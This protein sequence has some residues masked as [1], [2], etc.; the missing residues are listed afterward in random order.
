LGR[1]LREI[2]I[3]MMIFRIHKE[4][5]VVRKFHLYVIMFVISILSIVSN[6]EEKKR[7]ER[8]ALTL[9]KSIEL[10]LENN[11]DILIAKE[12]KN[13]ASQQIREARSGA[14]P[15]L[16]YAA[17]YT[18]TLVKPAFYV[19]VNGEAMKF[20]VGFSNSLM[21]IITLNQTLYSGGRTGTAI[22]IASIYSESFDESLKQTEK[23]VRLQVRQVFLGVL[24]NAEVLKI[25]RRSQESA[26]K[27]FNMVKTLHENGMASEFDLLR[28]EVELENT[29]PKVIQSENSLVLQKNVLKNLIGMPLEREIDII[30]TL[31]AGFLDEEVIKDAGKNAFYNRNDYKNFTLMRNAYYQNIRIERAAWFPFI[32]AQYTYQHQ[33]QSNDWAF[34]NAFA[35]HNIALNLSIPLF[36]GFRTSARVQQAKI[37]VKEMDFQLIKLQEGINIQ[38]TQAHNS[39]A[40]ARKRI[41][42]TKKTVE[43]AQRAYNIALVRFESGQGTQ[44]EIF[45]AQIALELAQLN[46]LQG[47]FDYE[48]AKAQ[49]ENAVGR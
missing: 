21:H 7:P 47:I 30:G 13:R 46:R 2:M 36:D 45:D 38:I 27:H 22:K 28:A 33:G 18:R 32:G 25:N 49:W 16:N 9:E 29:R 1:R 5:I 42:S 37:N 48:I 23:N 20:E 35:S 34:K 6:G 26:E 12:G 4:D 19:S 44:L 10:A 40:D 15:Q 3:S 24:L 8:V 39:M 17:N 14:F 11:R 31:K 41:E 43:Q